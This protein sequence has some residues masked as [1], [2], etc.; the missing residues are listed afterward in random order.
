M[1]LNQGKPIDGPL[2]KEKDLACFRSLAYSFYR[3]GDYAQ[4]KM[5]FHRLILSK[6]LEQS[7][8]VGL[9]SC[10]QM[11][12]SYA[13]AL[14]V[15]GM[16]SILDKDDPFAHFHAATCHFALG[17]FERGFLALEASKK[18]LKPK[19]QELRARIEQ[20]ENKHSNKRSYS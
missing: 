14:K 18:L 7:Y 2:C 3:S 15:W 13:A 1:R 16:S 17:E 10:F 4:S 19:H 6:P 5:Y 9:G 20:M 8:W 11:E 12:K